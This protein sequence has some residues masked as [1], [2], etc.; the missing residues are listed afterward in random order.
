MDSVENVDHGEIKCCV[1]SSI[2][3]KG[4]ACRTMV[5]KKKKLH[6]D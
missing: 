2:I 6:L 1:A 5:K 4:L 3:R